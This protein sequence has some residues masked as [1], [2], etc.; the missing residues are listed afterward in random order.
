MKIVYGSG[1]TI[2]TVGMDVVGGIATPFI[3]FV[4]RDIVKD[5]T[6]LTTS[7]DTTV[8]VQKIEER[9]GVIIYV[10]NPD[11]ASLMHEVLAQLFEYAC[12][13]KWGDIEQVKAAVQ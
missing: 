9:G 10:E 5:V 8:S 7:G 11:A 2:L 4:D 6:G 12:G 3:G 13:G 1:K